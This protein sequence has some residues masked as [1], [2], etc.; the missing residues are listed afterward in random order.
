MNKVSA[1]AIL[2]VFLAASPACR[3]TP[4]P[5][6]EPVQVKPTE[7]P[8]LG[9]IA[10]RVVHVVNDDE[11]PAAGATVVI[12][13][14]KTGEAFLGNLE[15]LGA[16]R[17]QERLIE[18]EAALLNSAKA[19]TGPEHH[20]FLGETDQEGYFRAQNLPPGL[21]VVTAY[22]RAD[23]SRLMWTQPAVAKPGDPTLVKLAVPLIACTSATQ[24]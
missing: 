14:S 18:M 10:G 9:R 7:Q 8:Q 19:A 22:G 3:E 12:L 23:A 20:S 15:K 11:Q 21:Y 2:V 24:R 5:A 4:V 1:F 13:D 17:C 16:K 6:P